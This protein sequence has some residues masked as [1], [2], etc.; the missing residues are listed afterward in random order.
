MALPPLSPEARE[1]MLNLPAAH[2]PP[3]VEPNFDNPASMGTS[4]EA[5]LHCLYAL[6]TII[7][8]IKMY[9]TVRIERKMCI[10][11]YVLAMAWVS[12]MPY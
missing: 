7:F 6:S 8:F 11:D 12:R 5:A 1:K 9:G 2:P 10:E 3:G 4:A